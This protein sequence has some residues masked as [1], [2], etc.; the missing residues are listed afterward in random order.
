MN[1]GK[2]KIAPSKIVLTVH[3]VYTMVFSKERGKLKSPSK[4]SVNSTQG[5]VIFSQERAKQKISRP[6]IALTVKRVLCYSSIKGE[7]S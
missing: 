1:R 5:T 6:I 2:L 4:N 3:K 7:E